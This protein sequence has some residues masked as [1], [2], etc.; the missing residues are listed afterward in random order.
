MALVPTVSKNL[1][2][3]PPGF[4]HAVEARRQR[5]IRPA[6][7][8]LVLCALG[9]AGCGA[10][11]LSLPWFGG[12]PNPDFIATSSAL[13]VPPLGSGQLAPATRNW[14]Y[15]LLVWSGV[16]VGLAVLAIAVR[17]RHTH[18]AGRTPDRLMFCVTVAALVLLAL[19]ISEVTATIPFGD[20]PPLTYDFGAIVGL[21]LA[22]LSFISASYGWAITRYPWLA[23]DLLPTDSRC[24]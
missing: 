11:A 3:G 21:V 15:L 22:V 17:V 1:I 12:D 14:G 19:V 4:E 8:A 23:F 6:I 7:V 2:V 5:T 13:S 24:P 16:V 10:T 20:G 9:S 18:R